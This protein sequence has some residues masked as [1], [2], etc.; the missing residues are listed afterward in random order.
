MLNSASVIFCGPGGPCHPR[1]ERGPGGLH[2]FAVLGDSTVLVGSGPIPEGPGGSIT[3]SLEKAFS[4][5]AQ[6][7]D[8]MQ[9]PVL[10]ARLRQLSAIFGALFVLR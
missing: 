6:C 3:R 10:A 9:L 5:A 4:L 8:Q 2:V 7:S 1:S